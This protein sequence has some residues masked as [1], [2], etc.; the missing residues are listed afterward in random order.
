MTTERQTRTNAA[1][2][3]IFARLKSAPRQHID[4]PLPDWQAW[5]SDDQ[6]ERTQRFIQKLSA[7]HA[8]IIET[9][10]T[11]LAKDVATFINAEGFRQVLAGKSNP[12]AD[13]LASACEHTQIHV[14]DQTIDTFKHAL[15]N[16]IEAGITFVG[17]GIADTGTLA[18]VTGEQEPRALSLVPP[19]HIAIIRE[20]A[21]VSHFSELMTTPFWKQA[22]WETT[23]PTNL[24]LISGP[25]KT[26]DIQQT[27]AYGAHG[28]KRLIVFIVKE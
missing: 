10:E 18:T 24:L 23:P 4:V 2:E 28:P 12:L 9:T 6:S 16:D 7:S 1:R 19:T 8:E 15:F 11:D 27:L 17:A 20:S 14:Y 21:I 5:Q 25:S 22:G 13:A 3:A 26:A